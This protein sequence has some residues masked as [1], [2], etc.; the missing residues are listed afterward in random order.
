MA[1]YFWANYLGE[2]LPP[3][4]SYLVMPDSGMILNY[5]HF[6]KISF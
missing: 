1:A 2:K 3:S 6:S 5:P 4:I